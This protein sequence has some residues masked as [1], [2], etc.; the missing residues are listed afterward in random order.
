VKFTAI[1]RHDFDNIFLVTDSV[2]GRQIRPLL[3][4]YYVSKIPIYS[5]SSIYRGIKNAH[6]DQDLNGI[7]FCDAPFIIN[8]TQK[9]RKQ[10]QLLTTLWGND[11]QEYARLYAL[12]ADAYHMTLNLERMQTLPE[13]PWAGNTGNLSLDEQQQF[14][15]QL[16]CGVFSDGLVK[17]RVL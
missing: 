14:H 15:R 2:E 16:P 1:R 9:M 12:G 4:F 5:T 13:F 11:F 10:Q 17:N 8:P 6:D 7:N 3:T